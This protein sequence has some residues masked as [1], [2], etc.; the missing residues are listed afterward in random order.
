MP[1][2]I[3]KKPRFRCGVSG[4]LAINADTTEYETSTFAESAPPRCGY[5]HISISSAQHRGCRRRTV[6]IHG[7]SH[8]HA[9]TPL[10]LS[11]SPI[12]R[13]CACVIVCVRAVVCREDPTEKIPLSWT[14]ITT[15]GIS[16][17]YTDSVGTLSRCVGVLRAARARVHTL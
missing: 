16:R 11:F 4:V 7:R 3:F 6:E 10:F 17:T 9:Y 13:S 12:S 8:T 1:L 14:T 5:L 2:S 15:A